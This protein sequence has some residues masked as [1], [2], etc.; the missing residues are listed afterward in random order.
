[1]A[2]KLQGTGGSIKLQGTDGSIK[3]QSSG[4]GGG[5][6]AQTLSLTVGGSTTAIGVGDPIA[7]TSGTSAT[8]SSTFASQEY[9]ISRTNGMGQGIGTVGEV[10]NGNLPLSLGSVNFAAWNSTTWYYPSATP[11]Q[12]IYVYQVL[13][14]ATFYTLNV[15]AAA[16]EGGGGGGFPIGGGGGFPIGGGGM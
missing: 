2:I 14:N 12:A 8:L 13:T 4:G 11:G 16:P 1:M 15:E 5:G 10:S 7:Y 3:M 6:G 9:A